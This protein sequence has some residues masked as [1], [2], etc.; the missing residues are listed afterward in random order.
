MEFNNVAM[1]IMCKRCKTT[2]DATNFPSHKIAVK[3]DCGGWLITPTGA[4]DGRLVYKKKAIAVAS[5]SFVSIIIADSVEDATNYFENL[6]DEGV[7]Q[8]NVIKPTT[9]QDITFNE[10][11][12]YPDGRKENVV[13]DLCDII[14]S[15]QQNVLEAVCM[16][17][18]EYQ[19]KFF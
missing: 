16:T 19:Q 11:Y 18:E 8:T 14:F 2:T 12:E 3:C 4:F 10:L 5:N 17:M 7:L 1:E 15:C 13:V 9:Y 6:H